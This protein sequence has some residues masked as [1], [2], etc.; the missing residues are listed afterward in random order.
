[1]EDL[2]LIQKL[3]QRKNGL[4]ADELALGR[5]TNPLFSSRKGDVCF[6][7]LSILFYSIEILH[8]LLAE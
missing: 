7:S 1:M 8:S 6:L 3:R 2:K 4:S 5:Q